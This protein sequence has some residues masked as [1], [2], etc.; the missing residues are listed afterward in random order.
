MQQAESVRVL[1]IDPKC[2]EGYDSIAL[3]DEIALSLARHDIKAE[4]T[5]AHSDGIAVGAELLNQ[6]A[7]DGCD[8][9]SMRLSSSRGSLPLMPN[10]FQT[11]SIQGPAGPAK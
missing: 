5:V 6:V 2:R 7:D 4:V 8:L 10:A 11:D 9:R 1:A 3:G